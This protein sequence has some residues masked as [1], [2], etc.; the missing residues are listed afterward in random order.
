M[1][2]ENT[3]YV[4]LSDFDVN[5]ECLP[6]KLIHIHCV[7]QMHVF[8]MSS[9]CP[10]PLAT[11]FSGCHVNKMERSPRILTDVRDLTIGKMLNVSF[12]IP[13]MFYQGSSTR[14]QVKR[15]SHRG[16]LLLRNVLLC[17]WSSLL[18]VI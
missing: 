15:G 6:V 17:V 11:A 8:A 7:G 2:P 1:G 18:P 9:I 5:T 14:P 13:R 10:P 16:G 3:P 12:T 4:T